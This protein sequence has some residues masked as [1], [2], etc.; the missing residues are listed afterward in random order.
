MSGEELKVVRSL[1]SAQV[2]DWIRAHGAAGTTTFVPFLLVERTFLERMLH[3]I[4]RGT[5]RVRR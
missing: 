1:I 3:L 2:P 4:G 5:L